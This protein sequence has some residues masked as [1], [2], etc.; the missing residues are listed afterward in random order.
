MW[1]LF[2]DGKHENFRTLLIN[3]L[4]PHLSSQAFDYWLHKGESTFGRK[5]KGLYYTGG[6]RHAINLVHWLGKILGIGKDLKDLSQ[7]AT[8]AEQREIWH[9]RVRRVLLSQ[10]LTY[11]VIGT[12]RFLWKALG[13]PKFQREMIEHDYLQQLDKTA[14]SGSGVKSGQAIWEYG[15]NT[16]DPV[17]NNT[18][19]SEDNHYYLLCLQ[20]K[21]TQRCHPSYLSPKAH[22]RL[23][24]ES[25]F[26]GLRIHTD[27]LCEVMARMAPETLTIAVLMDS[28]D[29]FDPQGEEAAKQVRIVNRAL[30]LG[31]RVLLR[32]AGLKPWYIETFESLGF[33]PKRVG[34]RLPPGSCIDRYVSCEMLRG[35]M[36]TMS[37]VNMYASTWICTKI[38]SLSDEPQA[39]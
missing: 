12:E 39:G 5:A 17:V 38:A 4:A 22:V 31:G 13:V 8:L 35:T 25:A 27:E 32:S 19:V 3:D 20:G 6:S 9:R 14:S 28:M 29:W 23:S 16:L 1:K 36:L 26:D 33:S 21:Y 30:K 10:L 7:A 24:S 2:G 34:A 11:T 37:R 18:L 15:V